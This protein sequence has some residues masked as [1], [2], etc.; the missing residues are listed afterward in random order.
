MMTAAIT[1]LLSA[2]LK[3]P[4]GVIILVSVLLIAPMLV[5]VSEENILLHN[6]FHLFPT[7]MASFLSTLDVVQYELFGLVIR[8]YIFLPLFAL[9]VSVLLTPFTYRSFKNHQIV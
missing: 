2:K 3:S 5:S 9:T 4:F 6:I 1:M 7:Q 8:P